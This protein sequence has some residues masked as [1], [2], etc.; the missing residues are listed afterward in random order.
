MSKTEYKASYFKVTYTVEEA[1]PHSTIPYDYYDDTCAITVL[2]KGR[3]ICS[4]EGNQYPLSDGDMMLLSPDEIRSF[5]FEDEGYHERLSVYFSDSILLPLLEYDL[6]LVKVFH[7]RV[8][9]IGNKCSFD[10]Y[11]S[12]RVRSIVEEMKKLATQ[13][14]DRINTARLHTL[15]FQLLFW[16]YDARRAGEAYDDSALGDST[17]FEICKYIKNNLDKDLSYDHLQNALF[18]SRYQLTEVFTRNVGMTLTEYIVRKRLSKVI[19][20]VIGGEGIEAAAYKVGFHSY[21]NFYKKFVK[22]YKMSPQSFFK[23]Q[24]KRNEKKKSSTQRHGHQAMTVPVFQF[25]QYVSVVL[26][27]FLSGIWNA[28]LW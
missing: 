26:M 19:S 7:R 21:P 15:I 27:L 23:K 9:G 14:H 16:V 2:I 1:P 18:V 17:A 3:G 12:G 22:Y 6:P 10:D 11:E 24:C 8:L 5:R 4:V 28:F 13:D 20:L 25:S